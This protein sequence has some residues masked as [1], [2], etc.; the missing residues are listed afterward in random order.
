MSLAVINAN[1]KKVAKS[2]TALNLL[3]QETAVLCIQHAADHGDANPALRLC[4][5]MPKTLR[6]TAL[7]KW[8]TLYSPISVDI[9]NGKCRLTKPESKA[10]KPFDV[11]GANANPWFDMPEL[12]REEVFLTIEDFDDKVV[13]LLGRMKKAVNDGKVVEADRENFTAKINAMEGFLN[14][15][16]GDIAF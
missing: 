11:D 2:S 5:A 15:S 1:I 14:A 4:Q 16:G 12:E 8:F 3:I 7:A 13:S 9:T 6:R 10:F